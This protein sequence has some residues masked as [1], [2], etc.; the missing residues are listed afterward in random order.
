MSMLREMITQHYNHPSIVVW[1]LMNETERTQPLDDLHWNYELCV[2]LN[3]LAKSLDP[4]RYTTQAQMRDLGT[5]ILKVT[6][7]RGWNR[8]FGWYYDTFE[9]FGK[10]MDEQKALDSDQLTLISDY[11]AGSKSFYHKERPDQSDFT[12]VGQIMY[13]RYTLHQ[14][15]A[16]SWLPRA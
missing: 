3:K 4:T 15:A 2:D 16:R 10:F 1:G 12:E 11:G 5:G 9:D 13:P 8:Y 7:I 14:I 6:D